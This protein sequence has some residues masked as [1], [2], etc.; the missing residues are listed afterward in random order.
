M[1]YT[2]FYVLNIFFIF[3]LTKMPIHYKNGVVTKILH[4]RGVFKEMFLEDN[5]LPGIY[6]EFGRTI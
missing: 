5:S 2:I 6:D 1:Y 4:L 3:L